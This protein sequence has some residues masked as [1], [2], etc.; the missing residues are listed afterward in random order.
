MG[1]PHEDL[2][3]KTP[4]VSTITPEEYLKQIV[5]S[6]EYHGDGVILYRTANKYRTELVD[7]GLDESL[8][9]DLPIR[10]NAFAMAASLVDTAVADSESDTQKWKVTKSLSYEHRRKLF[11]YGKFAFETFEELMAELNE[12][13]AGSGDLD[14]AHDFIDLNN[15]YSANL[16]KF[17]P[18]KKFSPEMLEQGMQYHAELLDL[19]GKVNRPEEEMNA[20]VTLEKQTFTHFKQACK[21]IRRWARFTFADQPEIL[22]E[23]NVNFR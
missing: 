3:L 7:E 18:L 12:I 19:Y 9:D 6:D 10:A 16:D 13:I 14:L 8:I 17:A 5:S 22:E 4:V 1:T 15:L 11:R 20:M 23:F 21:E 2:Q